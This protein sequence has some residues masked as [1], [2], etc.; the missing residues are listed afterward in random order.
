MDRLAEMGVECTPFGD[1]LCQMLDLAHPTHPP[2]ISCAP[3]SAVCHSPHRRLRDLKQCR[4]AGA[5][6]NTFTNV[7]KVGMWHVRRRSDPQFLSFEERDQ[8]ALQRE[9]EDAGGELVIAT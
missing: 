2:T 7:N 1:M 6:I 5:F 8:F 4:Q 3:A 9:R